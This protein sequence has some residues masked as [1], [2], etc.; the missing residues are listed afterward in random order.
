MPFQQ[1]PQE[2][3]AIKENLQLSVEAF[4]HYKSIW[5]TAIPENIKF[6]QEGFTEAI[7]DK[8]L[9]V[10][11]SLDT[12]IMSRTPGGPATGLIEEGYDLKSFFVKAKSCNWGPMSGFLCKEGC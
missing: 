8:F 3:K 7:V 5:H 9:A 12:V 10:A 11:S 1:L 6:Y 4:A 2:L